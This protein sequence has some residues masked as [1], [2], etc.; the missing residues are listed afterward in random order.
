MNDA[1]FQRYQ[2]A[3]ASGHIDQLLETNSALEQEEIIIQ[4]V[5]NRIVEMRRAKEQVLSGMLTYLYLETRVIY[6]EQ[7]QVGNVDPHYAEQVMS[8]WMQFTAAHEQMSQA[9]QALGVEITL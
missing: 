7:M 1:T 2:E 4:S 8:A 3:I 6:H 9:L 5:L